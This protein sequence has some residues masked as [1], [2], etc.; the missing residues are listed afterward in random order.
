M[1]TNDFKDKGQIIKFGGGILKLMPVTDAGLPINVITIDGITKADPAVVGTGDTG[2]LE[3]GDI[4]MIVGA[5][6]MIE[7]NDRIFTVANL[8]ADTSFELEGEDSSLH[9]TFTSGGTAEE[10]NTYDLGYI[11]DTGLRFETEV[12]DIPDETGQT[13]NTTEGVDTVK[14]EGMFM[15]SGK[16]LL[17]FLRDNTVNQYYRVY[18]K[19]TPTA[20]LNGNTQELFIGI[21]KLQRMMDVK[22]NTKRC[23]FEFTVLEN[24]TAIVVDEP[25]VA[26]G[27]VRATDVTIAA[28][29]YYHITETA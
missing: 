5:G 29:E 24:A 15:Q 27:S 11:N 3:N 23:P 1:A 18:Y 12:E 10:T 26:F 6:G 16:N 20:A 19:A 22:A 17:D 7:V 21:A 14:L 13:I 4:V 9:T 25:D 28:N 8:N 2:T